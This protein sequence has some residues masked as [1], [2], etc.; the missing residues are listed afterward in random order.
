MKKTSR[1]EGGAMRTLV[2]VAAGVLMPA[3]LW[4]Q[5]LVMGIVPQQS[6]LKLV[7]VWQPVAEHIERETGYRIVLK[8]ETSIPAFE[9][10]LYAGEYDLAYMNPYH[11]VVANRAQGYK[12]AVRADKQIVG[13]LVARKGSGIDKG[14]LAGRTFLFPAPF[15]FAA[16]LLTK[17]ELLETFGQDIEKTGSVR[18]VNSHDSVYKGVARGVGDVG[19]GIMRT[20]NNLGDAQSK[21]ALEIIHKTSAYPSHPVALKPS[22]ASEVAEALRRSFLTLPEALLGNLSMKRIIPTEDAE[23]DAVRNLARKLS[24]E[25]R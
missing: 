16:T 13:I 17:Y 12:A 2:V 8:I 15:A 11:Y 20:F 23:Y 4:A 24:I 1:R 7:K 19:G 18:Y 10:R 5:T 22:L 25:T 6:P 3:I 9:K 14:D 21:E